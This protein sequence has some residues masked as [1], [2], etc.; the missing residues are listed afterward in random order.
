MEEERSEQPS[1]PPSPPEPPTERKPLRQ[2]LL[3]AVLIAALFSVVA[4]YLGYRSALTGLPRLDNATDY[5]PLL[6][7]VLYDIKGRVAGEYGEQRRVIVPYQTLPKHVTNAFLAAEDAGFFHH[8]GVDIIAIL[9]AAYANLTSGK[10]R[11]GASTITQQVAKTFFL[12]PERTILRKVREVA[13]AYKLESA[14][15]KEEILFLYLN[16]IYFGE[17]AYGVEAAANVYFGKHITEVTVA[18]AAILAGLPKAPS[19]YSPYDNPTRA[20]QRQE[21]VIGQMLSNGFIT[22]AEADQAR[23]E[24]VAIRRW[25]NPNVLGGY[26]AEQVRRYLVETYGEQRVLTDGLRVE[27]SMDLEL[28]MTAQDAVRRGVIDLEKR[29]GYRGPVTHVAASEREAFVDKL[30]R[31]THEPGPGGVIRLIGP[32]PATTPV[33]DFVPTDRTYKALV[34]QVENDKA[35]LAVGHHKAV[36]PL[37]DTTWA[38]KFN[39]A[40][41]WTYMGGLTSLKRALKPGDVVLVQLFDPAAVAKGDKVRGE[42][43]KKLKAPTDAWWA[44]LVP[45]TEAQSALLSTAPETAELRAMIGGVDFFASQYNRAIQSRR[46]PGSSFK[47]I[48][49]AA[50]LTKGYTPAT[51]VVDSPDVYVNMA[52]DSTEVTYWKPK[53]YDD[54]FYGPITLREALVRSRNVPTLRIAQD[55]GMDSIFDTA[56]RLGITTPLQRDLSIALGSSGVSLY[57]LSMVYTTFDAGGV[58]RELKMIR[59]VLDRDGKIVEQQ[60]PDWVIEGRRPTAQERTEGDKTYYKAEVALDPQTNYLMVYLLSQVV[61]H[62]T[63]WRARELGRPAGGKTGTTNDNVDSWFVGFTPELVTGVWVGL[64][65]PNLN[66][67]PVETGSMAANPIWNDY[68]RRALKGKPVQEWNIPE[69]IVFHDVD[70]KTGFIAGPTS[71]KIVRMPFIY[72]HEPTTATSAEYRPTDDELL[73]LDMGF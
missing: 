30:E 22:Q 9:R 15:S 47:P 20:R 38:V 65:Q 51:M 33:D 37:F 6:P 11:Q 19:A 31:E 40:D 16:Q 66:L 46:Q 21:Y 24:Q 67:G 13:L 12:S 34:V 62:G 29:H 25:Q 52:E 14:L 57:E 4:G 45:R 73:K 49:Y 56:K 68:M 18:E 50:A 27:T 1:T 53:N 3:K 28:Q 54:T 69:N 55:I 5:R 32:T 58:R 42:K 26:Y 63:G 70:G 43:W 23:V 60:V 44:N 7:T 71:E 36:L 41:M 17:G 59:R 10:V 48:V 39:F 72:G 64:D 61:Q 35:E 2:R 8:G